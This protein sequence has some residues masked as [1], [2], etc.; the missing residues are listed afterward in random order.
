MKKPITLLLLTALL[1]TACTQRQDRKTAAP[2][3]DDFPL[4]FAIDSIGVSMTLK[5]D[6]PQDTLLQRTLAQFVCEQMF[7]DVD[8]NGS[9]IRPLPACQGDF[10]DFVRHCAVMKWE[11]LAEATFA[12]YPTQEEMDADPEREGISREEMQQQA[13][14][15]VKTDSIYQTA[16]LMTFRKIA[17][18]DSA[19]T[20][21]NEYD[22]YV[23]N[24]AHPNLGAV[25][26]TLRK[27][28]GSILCRQE[29]EGE[30][31]CPEPAGETEDQ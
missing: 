7:F 15:L 28:D 17:E 13:A 12:G 2:A 25:K 24:T 31:E 6:M 9:P 3:G 21:L 20:W 30:M 4:V 19:E 22:I 1:L 29:E 8:D 14:E 26:L 27:S 11:E 18:N 5:S 23:A 16:C 10:R